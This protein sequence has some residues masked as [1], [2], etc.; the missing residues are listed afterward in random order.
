MPMPDIVCFK[1][2]EGRWLEANEF[3]LK[4]FQLEGVDYRGKKDSE[5][6]AYSSFYQQAFLG[7]EASDEI[8]WHNKG[9]SRADEVIPCPD[10]IAKIFDIIKV[11]TFDAQGSRKGLIVVGRDI[12]ERKQIEQKLETDHN[13]LKV[14]FEHGGSGHLIVSSERII[15]QSEPAVLR[16][17][18]LPGAG[19][20]GAVG[21]YAAS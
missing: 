12:T 9:L 16:D 6:A 10:G 13:Y 2:A 19:T 5:L 1:D 21:S 14:L 18:G 11:P 4:L 3:D 20:A 7:C 17:D 8:A 15:V